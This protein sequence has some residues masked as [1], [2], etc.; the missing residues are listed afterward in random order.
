MNR[1][2][3]CGFLSYVIPCRSILGLYLSSTI[4][5]YTTVLSSSVFDGHFK[6][7]MWSSVLFLFVTTRRSLSN[8]TNISDMTTV[9]RDRIHLQIPFSNILSICMVLW[10]TLLNN[11][12]RRI[13]FPYS[14][15][16]KK[17][18]FQHHHAHKVHEI[19][20]S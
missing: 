18:S 10:C 3:Y 8:Y 13:G 4:S 19:N 14:I 7:E 1:V 11:S 9:T 16:G 17:G 6:R 20:N 12:S 5:R 2:C 15:Y